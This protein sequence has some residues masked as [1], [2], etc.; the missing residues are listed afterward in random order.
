[1]DDR[2]LKRTLQSIGK[3]FFI[4]VYGRADANG[5]ELSA[6]DV[7]E[8]NPGKEYTANS[9]RTRRSGVK[10]IFRSGKQREAWQKC[11]EVRG[12]G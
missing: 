5:G 10:R 6:Q 7:A 3:Q 2:Q 8:L 9:V 1:M 4:N 12:W 11:Q